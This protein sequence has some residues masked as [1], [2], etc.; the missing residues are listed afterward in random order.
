MNLLLGNLSILHV[1][2]IDPIA[3]RKLIINLFYWSNLN[4]S[5]ILPKVNDEVIDKEI[6][7]LIKSIRDLQSL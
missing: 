3:G 2:D 5:E 4:L 1:T 7:E 6:I